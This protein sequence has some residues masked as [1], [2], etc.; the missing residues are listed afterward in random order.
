MPNR[1]ITSP[2]LLAQLWDL[3]EL[4]GSQ[5]N[6]MQGL[7]RLHLLLPGLSQPISLAHVPIN[8][9]IPNLGRGRLL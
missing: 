4:S 9:T 8:P 1:R 5:N 7:A 3:E 2:G 6:C